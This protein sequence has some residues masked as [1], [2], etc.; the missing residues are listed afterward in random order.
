MT[1]RETVE[2]DLTPSGS[3]KAVRTVA[4]LLIW[5]AP[6]LWGAAL[7]VRSVIIKRHDHDQNVAEISCMM[8]GLM[9]SRVDES[10]SMLWPILLGVAGVVSLFAGLIVWSSSRR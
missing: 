10:A 1:D 9:C 6:I 3:D 5:A 2:V 7:I 4:Q 8:Y